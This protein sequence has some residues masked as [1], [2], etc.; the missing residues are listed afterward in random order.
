MLSVSYEAIL[1][2]E[3][4]RVNYLLEGNAFSFF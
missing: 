3:F 4:E 1:V 2:L